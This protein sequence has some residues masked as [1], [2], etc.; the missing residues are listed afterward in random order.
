MWDSGQPQHVISRSDHLYI[1]YVEVESGW[2]VSLRIFDSVAFYVMHS[3]NV[4]SNATTVHN[5]SAR[6]QSIAT[7][8]CSARFPLLLVWRS[9]KMSSDTK[10][11]SIL[12][13]PSWG[14]QQ[15]RDLAGTMLH[16][17]TTFAIEKLVQDMEPSTS[18]LFNKIASGASCTQLAC[19]HLVMGRARWS[20]QDVTS[21][22]FQRYLSHA[23]RWKW[24]S[25]QRYS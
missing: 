4:S 19:S 18:R 24:R 17:G 12:T 6:I 25:V 16:D 2:V 1:S 5:R 3:L 14:L 11:S 9:C 13:M 21:S 22:F 8:Y 10:S 15:L 23:F 20:L 7:F